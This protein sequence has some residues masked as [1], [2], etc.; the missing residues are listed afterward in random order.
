MLLVLAILEGLEKF[1]QAKS[2]SYLQ[3]PFII[4]CLKNS[5]LVLTLVLI[6]PFHVKIIFSLLATQLMPKMLPLIFLLLNW[7]ANQN[8]H[9]RQTRHWISIILVSQIFLGILHFSRLKIILL[10]LLFYKYYE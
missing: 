2:N 4:P 3:V 9:W 6:F 1:K 8:I 7:K 5:S 10:L